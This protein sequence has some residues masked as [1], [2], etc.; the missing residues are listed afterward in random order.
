[1]TES[2]VRRMNFFENLK[3]FY[4]WVIFV[5]WLFL[6]FMV[7]GGIHQIAV[8]SHLYQNSFV[9]ICGSALGGLVLTFPFN[10]LRTDAMTVMAWE[11]TF[12]WTGTIIFVIISALASILSAIFP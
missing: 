11:V 3:G 9:E 1:M 4:K 10:L 7:F 6:W 5:I 8:D 12:L 2:E